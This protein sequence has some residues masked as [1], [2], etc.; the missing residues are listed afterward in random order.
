MWLVTIQLGPSWYQKNFSYFS[1]YFLDFLETTSVSV[2]L[3]R[4]WCEAPITTGLV[5]PVQNL[6][7]KGDFEPIVIV[8]SR[9]G[10]AGINF[11]FY[12]GPSWWQNEGCEVLTEGHNGWKTS[13]N[14]YRST[15]NLKDLLPREEGP[16]LSRSYLTWSL[17]LTRVSWRG[18]PTTRTRD[19]WG[20][21]RDLSK[22]TLKHR[23]FYN[24]R[25]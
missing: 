15:S 9:V 6:A 10:V 1:A 17:A 2:F 18:A 24:F 25:T 7:V 20:A 13:T 4:Q 19:K 21:S 23:L 16:G 12:W 3:N 14:Y 11:E 22:I 5:M 8:R